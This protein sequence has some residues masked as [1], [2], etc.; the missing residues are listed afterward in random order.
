M[1]EADYKRLIRRACEAEGAK[2][3]PLITGEMTAKGEPDILLVFEGKPF[4]LEAK[5]YPN[6]QPTKIQEERLSE[7]FASGAYPIVPVFPLVKP[8]SVAAF[9]VMLSEQ[10][11]TTPYFRSWEDANNYFYEFNQA[12]IEND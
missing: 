5:V 6:I 10:E 2:T 7:W 12:W 4:V 3:M 8:E 9:L 1:N 11:M